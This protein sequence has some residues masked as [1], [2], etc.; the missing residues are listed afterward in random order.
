VT[1]LVGLETTR[2]GKARNLRTSRKKENQR[3]NIVD[4][5]DDNDNMINDN[6]EDPIHDF[7]TADHNETTGLSRTP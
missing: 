2:M 4:P 7:S 6:D 5:N 1:G 3:G